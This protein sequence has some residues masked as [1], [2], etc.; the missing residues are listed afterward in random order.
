MR[1]E[2][3]KQSVLLVVTF[4]L[5]NCAVNA[6][7]DIVSNDECLSCL[8][9]C[10]ASISGVNRASLTKI[11][12]TTNEGS[13]ITTILNGNKGYFQI[14][15]SRN[16]NNIYST[17]VNVEYWLFNTLCR[18]LRKTPTI[19]E[20]NNRNLLHIQFQSF[21]LIRAKLLPADSEGFLQ[22]LL[23][24]KVFQLQNELKITN[25]KLSING[26]KLSTNEEKIESLE[27]SNQ[28]IA[29]Q[30]ESN[31]RMLS[32]TER[33]DAMRIKLKGA[34]SNS[35]FTGY[36]TCQHPNP[37]KFPTGNIW[38]DARRG[39]WM[40]F[41]LRETLTFNLIRFRLYDLDHRNY[42]YNVAI[43]RSKINWKYLASS[44]TGSSVQEL[45]LPQPMKI[46]YIKMEGYNSVNP[47]LHVIFVTIDW[48]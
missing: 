37:I 5:I 42:T 38:C 23:I 29:K 36:K 14:T 40:H 46:R 16:A 11:F 15:V 18:I 20:L 9:P 47:Y 2:N 32:A 44:K 41:D 21:G 48:E 7:N 35:K 34:I 10:N 1:S 22:H 26:E 43:S 13:S 27:K 19:T 45:K 33:K 24:E 17:K 8:M 6:R 28:L 25:T 4:F 12:I 39:T 31:K 30:I 3:F